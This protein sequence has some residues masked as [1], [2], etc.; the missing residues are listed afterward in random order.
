[1]PT[2]KIKRFKKNFFRPIHL[3]TFLVLVIYFFISKIVFIESISSH[4]I[5]ISFFGPFLFGLVSSFIFLYLFSHEEFFH[6]IK[7]LE[8]YEEKKE[9]KYI[10]NYKHYGK[11]LTTI[12]IGTVG[13]TILTALTIRLLLINYKYRYLVLVFTMLLSTGISVS[14][15]RGVLNI[16]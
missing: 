10:K 1:M 11:I 6:F 7:D 3:Q 9:K 4:N 8:N 13:G 14:I 12:I 16:I 15:A 5:F 2:S